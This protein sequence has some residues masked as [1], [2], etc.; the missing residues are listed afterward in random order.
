M[1]AKSP[2]YVLAMD[3][4][5]I[6]QAMA[7]PPIQTAPNG[8]FPVTG[9]NTSSFQRP[10]SLFASCSMYAIGVLTPSPTT[11]VISAHCVVMVATWHVIA[12]ETDLG[13]VLY[14][15]VSPYDLR[16]WYLA[17]Q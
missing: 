17:L 16:A 2:H 6:T 14:K 12:P 1:R 10:T 8:P 11:E 7:H 15:V 13:S 9:S 3:S 4:Q 5:A